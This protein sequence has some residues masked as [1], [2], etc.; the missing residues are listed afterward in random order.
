MVLMFVG[1]ISKP[2]LRPITMEEWRTRFSMERISAPFNGMP[3]HFGYSTFQLGA[4]TQLIH[5]LSRSTSMIV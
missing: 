5:L 1:L 3:H 4:D 2:Y